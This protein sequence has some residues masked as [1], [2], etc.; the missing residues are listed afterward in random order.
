MRGLFAIALSG[1]CT[2]MACTTEF[3][4]KLPTTPENGNSDIS[5]PAEPCPATASSH[6]D[7]DIQAD[8]DALGCSAQSC[9]G[10]GAGML[11]LV[12]G[13]SG[14]TL[15]ANYAAFK[16]RASDGES[17]KVLRKPTGA[18]SHGGGKKFAPGD[19]IYTRWLTWIRECQPR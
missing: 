14:D 11:T 15:A 18:E 2:L 17:S 16:A 1:L 9:H 5:A 10:G 19:A 6:F 7:T 8:I 3:R 13:A 12:Q 4:E